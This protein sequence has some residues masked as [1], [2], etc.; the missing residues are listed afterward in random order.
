MKAFTIIWD[1]DGTI[2]PLEPFD[3]E[4]SLLIHRMSQ[5][6]KPFGWL[7]KG[8][9]RAVIY[10]DRR[11]WFRKTFKK[12]YI[13]LLKGTKSSD[14]DAVCRQL[15]DNISAADRQTLRTLKD[16]GHEMMVLSCGTAD[17]SERILKFAELIDCFGL[18]EGNRFQIAEGRISGMHLPLADPEDKLKMAKRLNLSPRRTIVVGD[19]YT[20]LPL[21][22]WSTVPVMIDRIGRK[23]KD[24]ASHNFYFI[25][26]VPEIMNIVKQLQNSARRQAR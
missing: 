6:E 9:T 25:R 1:F 12:S 10:A 5:T 20:D 15:A 26:A 17:L 19:G 23:K 8:Y 4:Q 7:K 24:F 13:R 11:Q 2:L 18:I 21:L 22:K 3:S 16:D 14:L